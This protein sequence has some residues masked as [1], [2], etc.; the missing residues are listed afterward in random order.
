MAGLFNMVVVVAVVALVT[1]ALWYATRPRCVLHLAIQE[2]RLRVV[3]GKST[4]AFLEAAQSICAESGL[5]SGDIR[6]YWRGRQVT[7]AFSTSIPPDIQQRLR[8][9]WLLAR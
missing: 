6:G 5:V 2:G 1:A 7:L 4:S 8:N 3:R 9:V